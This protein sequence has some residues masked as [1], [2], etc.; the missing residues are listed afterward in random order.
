M[1]SW[2]KKVAQSTIQ[3]FL[4]LP[5][6]KNLKATCAAL[7]GGVLAGMVFCADGST[8]D[9][10]VDLEAALSTPPGAHRTFDPEKVDLAIQEFGDRRAAAFALLQ[11]ALNR[12]NLLM[13]GGRTIDPNRSIREAALYGMG[14]LGNSVPEVQA[15]LWEVIYSPGRNTTDRYM[16]FR[17]LQ[18]IGF[19]A[20]DIPTLAK[21]LAS[22]A[23]DKNILTKLVPEAIS[24][25]IESNP[26]AAK[27]FLA[28]L[29]NL[30]EDKNP[31]TQFRAALA[32]VKSEGAGNPKI[33]SA[34]HTLFQRPDGRLSNYYKMLAAQILGEAG[35]AARPLVPDL[36]KFA[37]L[38]DEDYTYHHIANIAPELGSQVPGVAQAV[39]DRQCAQ[40]WAEKWK[41][42]AYTLD[43]LRTA[44]KAPL[45]ALIA[46]KHLG[47][48]GAAAKMAVPDMIRAMWG[49]D[50]ES[51]DE[52]L[53]D[54]HKID[55]Q[56][57][58]TKIDLNQARIETGFG[59]AR[60][61]LE[62]MPASPPLKKLSDACFQMEWLGGWILP[63]E[64]SS[65]TNDLA[66]LAPEAYRAYLKGLEP[67]T[68][69]K[70]AMNAQT[71]KQP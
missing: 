10:A 68:C 22:P 17:A 57:S 15:F 64:L 29:Q 50:G 55:P 38:P 37:R 69:G 8:T 58:V 61:A 51:R 35:A 63:E 49:K 71:W 1:Y 54:I 20:P 46:A 21:L 32:L 9:A 19:Q 24:N 11:A 45:Q 66:R 12:T 60:S 62:K 42:G 2:F 7:V 65:L 27:H 47:E 14:R 67:P 30:L 59:S 52:I 43:D 6:L 31:D 70:P 28:C 36:L 39:Q 16:A 48:M 18:N 25:L 13:E 41:S 34:L 56:I 44:L 33:F 26:P 4:H 3:M 5:T 23:C 40:M 53:A